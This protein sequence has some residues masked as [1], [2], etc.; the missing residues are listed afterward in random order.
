[1]IVPSER[2]MLVAAVVVV[3]LATAAGFV[4]GAALPCAITLVLLAAAAAVDAVRSLELLDGLTLRT[5]VFLR[6]TKD[7]PTSLPV[8]IENSRTV[9]I[10]LK[11]SA[12]LPEGVAS[13]S[14]TEDVL[15]PPGA[16]RFDWRATGT[17]R[18]DHA[19]GTLHVEVASPFG[20]WLARAQRAAVC[21]LRVYPNLRDRA[22]ASLFLKRADAGPRAHRLLG[23]GR[24]FDNLRQYMPGDNFEDIYWKATARRHFPVVKLFR[25]E[26]AQEVYAVID[27]SRLSA[28]QDILESYVN[29]A[30]HLALVA[31][32]QGDRF[33]LVTFSDRTHRFLRAG[34]GLNHF[35][36]CRETI[37]NLQA[38]KVSPDFR[39]V[40]TNL[41]LNLRRRALLI[42]F[43]SLDDALLAETFERE[44][45]LLARRHVV[46]VNV[47]E[48]ALPPLFSGA[49]AADLDALYTSL[50]GQMLSNRM[51]RLAIALGNRGVRLSTVDSLRIKSQVTA[52]Y[53]EVKRRQIL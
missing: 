45:S 52:G 39:D 32:R 11:L 50:A 16:S 8:F 20:L 28:R 34:S 41:Q 17:A 38:R 4:P 21:A 14:L 42:F 22:T 37:Y 5:P 53:L 27:A 26:H 10:A 44:I 48:T 49:P 1:M 31:E 9:P 25:A 12:A 19:L 15:A 29:A 18:G 13:E 23:K 6:L 51:R 36:L 7:I 3:P 35:R 47:T 30:L 2:L 46:L 33:G 43:T 24:E 40:F